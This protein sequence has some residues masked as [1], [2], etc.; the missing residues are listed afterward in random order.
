MKRRYDIM[1]RCWKDEPGTRPTFF[2]LRNQLKA[3]ETLHKVNSLHSV[4]SMSDH[5]IKYVELYSCKIINNIEVI[6]IN[7]E[8]M[9]LYS[10]HRVA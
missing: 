4:I 1:L 3:M 7:S 10:L 6:L 8:T 9:C 5:Y 2:D